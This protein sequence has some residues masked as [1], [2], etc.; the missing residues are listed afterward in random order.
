MP[1]F[2]TEIGEDQNGMYE[3]P[4]GYIHNAT[5]TVY[6]HTKKT[7][8]RAVCN[9]VSGSNQGYFEQHH[10]GERE[11]RAD[12]LYELMRV[13]ISGEREELSEDWSPK[14]AA[15]IRNAIAKAEDALD[16]EDVEAAA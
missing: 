16:E 6:R 9:D 7:R 4:G 2:W 14:M 1:N 8:F 12:S 5:C 15:A 13:A 11:Y 10:G 3:P